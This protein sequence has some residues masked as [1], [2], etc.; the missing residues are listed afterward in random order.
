MPSWV[1]TLGSKV[2]PIIDFPYSPDLDRETPFD[3]KRRKIISLS[4]ISSW[5]RVQ[6]CTISCFED[7]TPFKFKY[8]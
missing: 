4:Y 7:S 3:W 5:V 6:I 1:S 8:S 2:L